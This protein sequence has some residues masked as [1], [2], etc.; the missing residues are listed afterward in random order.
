MASNIPNDTCKCNIVDPTKIYS[1]GT[2]VIK[3]IIFEGQSYTS[4]KLE[5]TVIHRFRI[6]CN[7]NGVGGH[8]IE[9]S[10]AD[11]T[12]L[13]I[14]FCVI[15]IAVVF[16]LFYKLKKLNKDNQRLR[17]NVAGSTS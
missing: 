7:K 14:V 8:Y 10:S 12:I 13:A 11:A 4:C 5:D 15:L 1:N 3:D 6:E 16:C 2:M 17:A 9:N